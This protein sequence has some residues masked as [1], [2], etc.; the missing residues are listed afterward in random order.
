M[1]STLDFGRA[2]ASVEI[3][4]VGGS[5]PGILVEFLPYLTTELTLKQ[6]THRID[7]RERK[8]FLTLIGPFSKSGVR[9]KL[10]PPSRF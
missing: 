8:V 4:K 7:S 1:S 9:A 2:A 3:S 10:L 6:I 5:A